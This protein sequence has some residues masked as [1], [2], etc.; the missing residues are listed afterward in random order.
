MAYSNTLT[1]KKTQDFSKEI[2]PLRIYGYFDLKTNSTYYFNNE[3]KL[4]VTSVSGTGGNPEWGSITGGINNQTDLVN[5]LTAKQN[6]NQKGIA[7]GYAGLD[8]DGKVPSSQLPSYVD[9]VLEFADLASL[10]TIGQNG[11]I[12]ITL[13]TNKGFRWTGSVY[14]E[15][16]PSDV[17]SVAGKTGIVNLVKADVGLANA[18]NTSDIGKPISTATQTALNLKANIASPTFT[19]TLTAP[20][21]TAD[22][23][24]IKQLATPVTTLTPTGITQTINLALGNMFII[25]LS[26]AT[27]DVTLTIQ[28]L[29]AG[30]SCVFFVR[31]GATKRNLIFPTS[32]SPNATVQ[33]GA[34]SNI[35]STGVANTEDLI[36]LASPNGTKIYLSVNNNFA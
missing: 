31:Q 18:D 36:I 6:T 22:S 1:I 13:D 16:S 35:Y 17:N 10:P 14:F 23:I 29:L 5:T 12:Y 9:D 26:S 34:R 8:N 32:A 11:K 7:N 20:S 2:N 4:W 3:T 19:G 30:T 27:G 28:N 21:I 33:N 25:D 24:N 15:I